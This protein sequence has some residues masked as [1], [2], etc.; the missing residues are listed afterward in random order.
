VVYGFSLFA[1]P[2]PPHAPAVRR[3]S[4]S[5]AAF[6]ESSSSFGLFQLP[7]GTEEGY[8]TMW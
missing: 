2:T 1:P 8:S 6:Y 4:G 3:V 5:S 7:I